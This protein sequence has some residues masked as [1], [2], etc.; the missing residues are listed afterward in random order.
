MHILYNCTL[1]DLT[2]Q[3]YSAKIPKLTFRIT[4]LQFLQ[5]KVFIT[6][7]IIRHFSTFYKIKGFMLLIELTNTGIF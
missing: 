7:I 4:L 3:N 5:I 2:K 1:L 6:T